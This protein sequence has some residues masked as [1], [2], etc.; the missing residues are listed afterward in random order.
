MIP[1]VIIDQI[2]DANDIV[3]VISA[4]L[5]LKKKGSEFVALCPFHN[6]KTP[7]FYVVPQKQMFYC[8]GCHKG[9]DVF[10]FLCEYE[11][12]HYPEAI[13]RLGERIG[14]D[15]PEDNS[16]SSLK[17]SVKESMLRIHEEFTQYWHRQLLTSPEGHIA[18]DYLEKRGVSAQSIE[19][20]RLGYAPKL[21]EDIPVMAQRLHLDMNHLVESGLALARQSDGKN[22]SGLYGRFRGRLMFPI[23]DDQGHVIAFSA[24]VLYP[25]DK[26]GK[27]VNS[28]ET[29]LFHK[30]KVIYGLDRA[31]R[32]ITQKKYSIVCEGQLDLIS[33][34]AAGFRN[35][36]APQGTAFTMDQARLLK[37]FAPEVVL[38]FDGDNAGQNAIVKAFD[39]LIKSELSMKVLFLP[40]QHDPDSFIKAYGAEAFGKLLSTAHQFFDFYLAYLCQ[41]H[42]KDSDSGRLQIV[43]AMGEALNKADQPLLTDTY[44][45]KTANLLNVS[46]QTILD[47]FKRIPQYS[48]RRYTETPV[49]EEIDKNDEFID[50]EEFIS[51]SKQDRWLLKL[52]LMNESQWNW[53]S[54]YFQPEW[55]EN[56]S[57]RE[58]IT[59]I[60][61]L[62]T[63]GEW[64]Q[65]ALLKAFPSPNVQQF[66][67]ETLVQTEENIPE[68]ERQLQELLLTLR[69]KHCDRLL[70]NV[71]QQLLKPGISLD[72][73]LQLLQQKERIRQIKSSPLL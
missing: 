60:L 19:D 30:G 23:C 66:L 56:K 12:I 46:T 22:T 14:I 9:G 27:Y 10:K 18:R 57:V 37:R 43:Q 32:E 42:N 47:Q 39:I 54:Q 26:M 45:Q 41:H 24:R 73:Q 51:P 2:R 72:E 6:E 1:E 69:N 20:F 34:H 17:R 4:Y 8:H 11:H 36:V 21:W 70:R 44:A 13:R 65:N 59:Y 33:C 38:C 29:P 25:D 28:P 5:P 71:N 64:S 49:S 50:E 55:V 35:V 40:D 61:D 7:S 3:E 15:V 63:A 67:Y 52:L 31:K 53:V 58:I 68:K 48:E 62:H 16:E